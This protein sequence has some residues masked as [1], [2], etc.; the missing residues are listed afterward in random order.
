MALA[1]A[2]SRPFINATPEDAFYRYAYGSLRIIY[3]G[4]SG[5][6]GKR[7]CICL[8]LSHY[9]RRAVIIFLESG[10]KIMERSLPHQSQEA[11]P[12]S[13]Q[14]SRPKLCM[15][16]PDSDSRSSRPWKTHRKNA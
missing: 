10:V 9:A 6:Q 4:P 14:V 7:G 13:S 5:R 1:Q 3:L 15:S 12:Q 2:Y 8:P 16:F 11:L